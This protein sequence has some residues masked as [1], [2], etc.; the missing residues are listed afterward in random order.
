MNIQIC[1]LNENSLF[2]ESCLFAVFTRN[3]ILFF[4]NVCF[5]KLAFWKTVHLY[6][7][8]GI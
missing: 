6:N 5:V 2:S 4:D 3:G 8:E 1:L 7:Q